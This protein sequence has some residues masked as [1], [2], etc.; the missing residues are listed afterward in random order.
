MWLSVAGTML[1]LLVGLSWRVTETEYFL[2]KLPAPIHWHVEQCCW[3][4]FLKKFPAKFPHLANHHCHYP[5]L[6]INNIGGWENRLSPVQSSFSAP[7]GPLGTPLL[8]PSSICRQDKSRPHVKPC[9][10]EEDVFHRQY[11]RKTKSKE[12][13][14]LMC[15]SIYAIFLTREWLFVLTFLSQY[16]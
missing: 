6:L 2:A 5:L 13:P 12:V 8:V 7:Q 1:M 3:G 14:R 15:Y 10:K 9:R 16:N 11:K 4:A